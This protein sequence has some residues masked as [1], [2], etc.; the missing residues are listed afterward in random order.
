[1]IFASSSRRVSLLGATAMTVLVH[2]LPAFAE[3]A[4]DR[5][6]TIVVVATRTQEPLADVA[7]PVAVVDAA[8]LAARQ[9]LDFKDALERVPGVE[10]FGG[11]RP[12]A[13][14]PAI[15]GATGKQLVILLDGARQ[16]AAPG[17]S[18][19]IVLDPFFLSDIQVL[20]GASSALYGAGGIGGTLSFQ[21]LSASDL[22]ANDETF[23]ADARIDYQSAAQDYRGAVR[24]YGR[25]GALDGMAGLSYREWGPIEQG[26]GRILKP[27]DGDAT[28]AILKGGWQAND[29]LRVF[30]SH[31]L[32]RSQDFRPNNPQADATFPYIQNNRIE[33]DTS[34]IG[35]RGETAEGIED[36]S[37]TLYLNKY[38]I[39]ADENP[40]ES[41][42]ATFT[43]TE[44]LGLTGA[45]TL[46]F[47][48]GAI[49]HQLTI[50]GD[51]YQDD[52]TSRSGGEPDTV[53]PDGKQSVK[54]LFV[55]DE[56]ALTS[57][58][59]VSPALRYD[60]YE[61]SVESGVA[62]DS[63]DERLSPQITLAVRP[64][65]GFLMHATYGEAFRAPTI[66]EMFQSLDGA[67]WF[68]NFRPNPDLEPEIARE[69]NIGASWVAE[70]VIAGGDL[71]LRAD[72]FSARVENLITSKV[73]GFFF[74][75]FLKQNRPI[76]QSAN[77]G[78]AEREGFEVDARLEFDSFA[79][80]A[81]Y[82][83][84]RSEDANSG[85][86]LFAPPDKWTFGLNYDVAPS[87]N[88]R[89]RSAFVEAQDYDSEPLRQRDS[90]NVHDVFVSWTPNNADW[91]IDL[92][93][94]NIFD[95]EYIVYK[96]STAYIETYEEGRS[97]RIGLQKSF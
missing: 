27:G 96:Q 70:D 76:L 33:L 74:N 68:A 73:V 32:H 67:Q 22:L 47:D 37:V 12:Q 49:A 59:T 51:A 88:L 2:G 78:E 50:G 82:G 7:A 58:M 9:S 95:N 86:N 29:R 54:G 61:T 41:L 56:M 26:G 38:V 77:V 25:Q 3:E 4:P 30:A 36:L 93:V 17:F 90:Y 21:T 34:T 28:S 53:S 66:S 48:T 11:P 91:R 40:A 62:P 60:S 97:L 65:N 18:S 44:T 63:S 87:I 19:P 75:P 8:D 39:G 72:T 55:R 42:D 71:T 64:A 5:L 92:G 13:E 89:W 16:N 83:Q 46:R 57:W 85:A 79:L 69:F 14:L 6:D 94:T 52:I 35:V 20:K 10:F 84:I 23:G 24:A 81:A 31:Q 15:R 80:N 1:M 45:K 43:E